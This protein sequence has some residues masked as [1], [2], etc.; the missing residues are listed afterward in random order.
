MADLDEL[1]ERFRDFGRTSA[2]RSPL[3]AHLSR[4]I[5][6]DPELLRLLHT[7]PEQQQ[8]PV[9]LFAAVHHLVLSGLDPGLQRHYPNLT[10]EPDDGDAFPAFRECCQRHRVAL[11]H[12]LR[13][14]TTQTNEVGRCAQFLPAFGLIEAEMGTLAHLD[15]GTSAG[16]NV[17]LPHYEFRYTP[18][19]SVG[20]PSPV[21][22]DCA[23][24]GPVPVPT[25]VP[26]ISVSIGLDIAPIDVA[27]DDEVRWLEACVW[28]DQPDRFARLVAAIDLARRHPPDVRRG[29]ALDDIPALIAE[30]ADRGHPV[31]TN[32]WVLNYLSPEQRT[33]YVA[34]LDELG[35]ACDLSWVIAESPAQTPELPV[36]AASATED[37]TVLSLVTWRGGRRVSRRLATTHPHGFWLH[38]E[39]NS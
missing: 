11:T 7:A 37:L 23:T 2:S 6:G 4:R 31:L 21:V 9:L 18:G 10:A 26:D 12:L 34:L 32:S 27:D 3:Y 30:V 1:A 5:A 8:L 39:G 24:R 29:D 35:R 20:G 28:P 19:G 15:I 13:T 25:S 33:A 22:L 38:W 36:V 16:L 14:R 17:L